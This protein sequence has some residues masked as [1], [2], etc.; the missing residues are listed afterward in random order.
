MTKKI[1]QHTIIVFILSP[2][3]ERKI[4]TCTTTLYGI[5]I[6]MKCGIMLVQLKK[7]T[8]KKNRFSEAAFAL[9]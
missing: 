2:S 3:L 6:D 9:H 7:T 8:T 5:I 1:G 4:L